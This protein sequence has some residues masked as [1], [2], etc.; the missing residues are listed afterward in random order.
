MVKIK[1]SELEDSIVPSKL[2]FN[3]DGYPEDD[4]IDTDVEIIDG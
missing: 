4:E 3:F 2:W 1:L